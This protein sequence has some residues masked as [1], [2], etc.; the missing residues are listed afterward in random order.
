MECSS[1]IHTFYRTVIERWNV[2]VMRDCCGMSR[3]LTY[4]KLCARI[5]YYR[6]Q[7]AKWGLVPG[8]KIAICSKSCTDWAGLFMAIEVSGFVAVCL[9][10]DFL[11]SIPYMEHSECKI[12]YVSQSSVSDISLQGLQTLEKVVTLADN[13][14]LWDRES[15][16][17]CIPY[18][19]NILPED[20]QITERGVNDVA[21]IVYT[22]GSTSNIKGVLLTIGN[23]SANMHCIMQSFPYKK[24]ENYL[25]VLPFNHI[26]GLVY[27]VLMPMC[28][29]LHLFISNAPPVPSVLLSLLRKVK[30][31]MFFSVPL[32][33]Y[34]IIDEIISSKA[35]V[36][37]R[38][39]TNDKR[40]MVMKHFGGRC[41]LLITGGAAVNK[42]WLQMIY[43]VY[44][45]PFFIGYGMSECASSICLPRVDSYKHFSCGKP[46]DCLEF[47]IASRDPYEVPGEIMVRGASVFK[48]YYKDVE[49]TDALIDKDGWFHTRDLAIMSREGDV[50]VVGRTSD[51]CVA[52]SGQNIYL[53]EIEE[54]IMK[55]KG[56]K[57]AVVSLQ[58]NDLIASVVRDEAIPEMIVSKAILNINNSFV[59]GPYIQIVRWIDNVARTT[60][61]TI[62]RNMYL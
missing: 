38:M 2:E 42:E 17:L 24:S 14:I 26:F 59:N 60:K 51:M 44:D 58:N 15:Y 13:F 11:A 10:D 12:V 16:S 34:K 32:V 45:L 22:S 6:K 18:V 57:D 40:A 36:L 56:V 4:G 37:K 53:G 33:F 41:E 9:P 23:I 29:G 49:L 1:F 28:Y 50:F 31:S 55:I 7:W 20:F 43:S 47:V 25:S 62:K 5:E 48:G 27:D 21:V 35:N 19:D 61:G 30:P 46:I 52:A 8:D 39:N 54:K 3:R